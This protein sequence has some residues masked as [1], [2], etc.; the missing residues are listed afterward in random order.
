MDVTPGAPVTV[1]VALKARKRLG[2]PHCGFNTVAGYDTRWSESSW[3]HLDVSGGGPMILR[4]LLRRLRCPTRGV[5]VQGV[6]FARAESRF[7][8]DFEDL[9]RVATEFVIFSGVVTLSRRG[10]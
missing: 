6:P 1:T 4:M 8:T 3:R 2:C 7:N 10:G 9:V 5:V